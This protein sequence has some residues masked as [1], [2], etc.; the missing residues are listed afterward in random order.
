[1][2]PHHELFDMGDTESVQ[3]KKPVLRNVFETRDRGE[4]GL[5]K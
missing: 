5:Q 1:M 4:N 3:A 2:L